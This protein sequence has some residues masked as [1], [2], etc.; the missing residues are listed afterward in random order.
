MSNTR[1][2][3]ALDA[4]NRPIY[5]SVDDLAIQIV[6]TGGNPEYI[7]FARPGADVDAPVWKLQKLTYSGNNLVSRTWPV[8]QYGQASNDYEFVFSDYA[9]YTY[10]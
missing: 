1:P 4:N 9:S 10:A 3:N 5:D 8:N 2:I 7:G 6:Y